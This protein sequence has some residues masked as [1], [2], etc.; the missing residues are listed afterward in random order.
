MYIYD[1]PIIGDG[2]TDN[3]FRPSISDIPNIPSWSVIGDGFP[4]E[5]DKD[6][7]LLISCDIFI[8]AP[9]IYLIG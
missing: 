5:I 4:V 9:D 3:P 6:T 8:E 1:C 7:R 2:T